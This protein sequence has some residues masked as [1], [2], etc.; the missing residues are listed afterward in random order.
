ME[1]ISIWSNVIFA[2]TSPA[3]RR[4]HFYRAAQLCLA[5]LSGSCSSACCCSL[6]TSHS[7]IH[8]IQ[9]TSKPVQNCSLPR[10]P[11]V[12]PILLSLRRRALITHLRGAIE[13]FPTSSQS[14]RSEE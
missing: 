5:S 14:T 7:K 13:Y 4:Q 11:G 10:R 9:T 12:S 3:E 6:F 1:R 2:P 8:S